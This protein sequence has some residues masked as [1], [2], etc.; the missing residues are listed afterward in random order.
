MNSCIPSPPKRPP[1][2]DHQKESLFNRSE[3]FVLQCNRIRIGELN[4]SFQYLYSYCV[5]REPIFINLCRKWYDISW[6]NIYFVWPGQAPVKLLWNRCGCA[7][8]VGPSMCE[9][10]WTTTVATDWEAVKWRFAVRSR[11]YF[12]RSSK[13]PNW[14]PRNASTS[15]VIVAGTARRPEKVYAKSSLEVIHS[16]FKQQSKAV[17]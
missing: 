17:G 12:K 15:S 8:R 11:R 9:R 14:V 13:E 2:L 7:V 6:L 1:T 3:R 4:S 5:D 10:H 16:D